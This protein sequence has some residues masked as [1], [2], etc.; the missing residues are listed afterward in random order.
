MLRPALALPALL[1][2]GLGAAA[3]VLPLPAGGPAAMLGDS[4][5]LLTVE[6]TV[7]APVTQGLDA[8]PHRCASVAAAASGAVGFTIPAVTPGRLFTVVAT[9]ANAAAQDLDVTFYRTL[10]GCSPSGNPSTAPHANV[11]GN[12]AGTV[13][14]DARHAIVWLST[15]GAATFRYH[16]FAPPAPALTAW[17]VTN[18]L[19]FRR[20]RIEAA[21]STWSDL[22]E[23][24][25]AVAGTGAIYVTGHTAAANTHR[26]PT[27]VS[28]DDGAAWRALPD[29]EPLPDA[30]R[31]VPA[32][33]G[34]VGQ[35]NEGGIAA[36]SSGRAWLWDAAWNAGTTPLYG[37]C[38]D[39]A[40]ACAFAPLAFDF[41]AHAESACGGDA[42]RLLDKPWARATDEIVL[43]AS[44]GLPSGT[45]DEFNAASLLGAFD[46]ATGE[47]TWNVCAGVGGIPGVPALRGDGYVAVPQVVRDENG[48]GSLALHHGPTVL[49]LATTPPLL[50]AH[51]SWQPCSLFNGYASFDAR[52]TLYVAAGIGPGTLALAATRDF[53]A[54]ETLAW[55]AGGRVRY[56]W[57]EGSLAGGGALVTWAVADSCAELVPLTFYAAHATL[58]SGALALQRVSVVVADA[59]SPCGHYSGNDVGPDGRAYVV[60]EESPGGCQ[61]PVP[62]YAP[63]LHAPW[64]LYVQ[65]GGPTLT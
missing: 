60:V 12:E 40:R 65:D 49:D 2:L 21:T 23:P 50:P 35:G 29:P 28:V 41:A 16:E 63:T 17:T 54:F 30:T 20:A 24:H 18:E 5:P 48:L 52:D 55:N 3:L 42:P 44:A 27:F 25:V 9:G 34:R 19:H 14:A 15:G 53:E 13:P 31:D 47:A 46:P 32:I 7:A 8:A 33:G 10:G 22:Y 1:A 64:V 11:F 58:E 6:G 45:V 59:S 61:G 26:S 62:Q 37:W 39:G 43:L 38:D 4:Q 51:Q 36:D 57:V 56:L